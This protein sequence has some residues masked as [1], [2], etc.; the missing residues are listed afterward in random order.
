[1]WKGLDSI[2]L[3]LSVWPAALN[4]RSVQTKQA[5]RSKI[6]ELNKGLVRVWTYDEVLKKLR[7]LKRRKHTG[8]VVVLEFC[9]PYL[10]SS[11]DCLLTNSSANF[12][13]RS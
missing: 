2:S 6:V 4:T 5:L 7:G 8:R 13:Q 10:E 9:L 1:M 3:S 11:A 12:L